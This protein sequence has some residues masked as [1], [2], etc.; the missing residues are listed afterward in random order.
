MNSNRIS[1]LGTGASTATG[2]SV[3]EFMAALRSG[4]DVLSA[5]PSGDW[6]T[7]PKPGFE[8]RAFRWADRD[9]DSVRKLLGRKLLQV[10]NEAKMNLPAALLTQD[11]VGLILASTK[12]FT[13]DFV[14]HDS[15]EDNERDSL[16]PLIDDFIEASGL[17]PQRKLCVS[18]AC[19]SSLAALYVAQTWLKADRVDH[20][21]VLACDA[22][23]SFVLHGFHQLRVLSPDRTRPFSGT[24][25]GFHLGDAAACVVVSSKANSSLQLIDARID[26]EGH[27]ATRPSHSG[28]SLLRAV[29][30]LEDLRSNP[31]EL[32][33]AHGTSTQANDVTEDRVLTALFA[34]APTKPAVTGTKWSIGHTLGAAGLLDVI[35][36]TEVLKSQEP[37]SIF[38]TSEIDSQFQAR[39]L[40]QAAEVQT[41]LPLSKVLITSLGFGG[42]HAAAL[43]GRT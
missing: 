33:I 24:R 5:V 3:S 43:V 25:S 8:P 41:K 32:V 37:F 39:Y 30:S 42:V 10:F 29:S 16:T 13:E 1:I 20:V 4:K 27:A 7:P 26:S 31:P 22:I 15:N 9:T 40:A 34:D 12:G 36:A 35:A 21:V 11:R 38:T 23:D 14:W 18:N 17:K 2:S 6:A 19:A 28:E